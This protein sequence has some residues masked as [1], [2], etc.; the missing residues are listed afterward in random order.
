M[1]TAQVAHI[2]NLLHPT[3]WRGR[4]TADAERLRCRDGA[5]WGACLRHP[6]APRHVAVWV[7]PWRGRHPGLNLRRNRRWGASDGWWPSK[8]LGIAPRH[9]GRWSI[10]GYDG[11]NGVKWFR[12]F[13]RY[14]CIYSIV[15]LVAERNRSMFAFLIAAGAV[16]LAVAVSAAINLAGPSQSR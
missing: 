3:S 13:T 6:V 14:I 8:F 16:F 11:V 4:E 7:I 10:Q 5:G 12:A 9:G 2:Q 15:P 1:P